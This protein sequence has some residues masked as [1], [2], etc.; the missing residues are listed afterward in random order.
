MNDEQKEKQLLELGRELS[1]RLL[2]QSDQRDDEAL[3]RALSSVRRRSSALRASTPSSRATV[4]HG[5]W[6][7]AAVVTGA[8]AF[9]VI[10]MLRIWDGSPEQY[11]P[12]EHSPFLATNFTADEGPWDEN[13]DML[14]DMDFSLWLDMAGLEDAG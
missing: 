6:L 13:I 12:D 1:E 2:S 11:A 3:L 5:G 4:R 9:A 14:R 10:M 8:A 7:P